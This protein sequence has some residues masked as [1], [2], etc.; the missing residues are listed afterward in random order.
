MRSRALLAVV[1]LAVVS[2]VAI[3]YFYPRSKPEN[4]LR[5]S[6]TIEATDVDVAFQIAGRVSEVTA[7]EG[8]SVK[9]GDVVARLTVDDLAERVRQIEAALDAV[10]SQARQQQNTIE[11]RRGVIEGQVAQARNQEEAS[12]FAVDRLKEGLRPQEI[13]VAEADLAQAEA[14]LAQKRADFE[15]A[16]QLLKDGIIPRQQMDAAEAAL[17][18]AEAARNAATQR[19]ALA[20]EGTRREDI[21]EA[22]ARLKAAQAGSSVAE[23]GRKEI[24]VQRAALTTAQARERELRVELETAKTVRGRAE[25]HSPINGVVLTKN[26]ESG[27]VVNP[28]TPVVTIANIDELWMNIYVPETQTGKVRLDQSVRVHVDAFPEETFQGRVTFISSE[29]EFTP[30]TILTPEERIKLV[31]RVKV[32]LMDSQRRLKP[33]MPADA[34]I[35]LAP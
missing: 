23:A 2:A 22:E 10:T 31:F 6:G 21:A 25:I 7:I 8:Q 33:G 28:G 20:R 16:S 4:L 17:R 5:A 11:L 9:A 14:Q 12:R 32:M 29:S 3:F 13:R 24:D 27:E 34:E 26:V 15:R 30:K 18:T 35:E 19:L 1:V